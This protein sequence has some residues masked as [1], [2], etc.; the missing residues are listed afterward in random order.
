VALEIISKTI[1]GKVP[2]ELVSFLTESLPMK[3]KSKIRLGVSDNKLA[4]AISEALE[5]KITT[6]PVVVEL[7][8]GFRQHLVSYL[9]NEEF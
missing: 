8:R 1:N 9:K 3:K 7:M 5:I 4:G 2:E 6:S